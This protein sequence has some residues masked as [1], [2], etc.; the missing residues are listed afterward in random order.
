MRA[1]VVR[2]VKERLAGGWQTCPRPL[3]PD[4]RDG[5]VD[6]IAEFAVHAARQEAVDAGVGPESAVAVADVGF[7]VLWAIT[8]QRVV[9]LSQQGHPR[10]GRP[11][12]KCCRVT[13]DDGL[14]Y[15]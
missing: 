1:R 6:Q 9:D 8:W 5:F 2:V 7:P 14:P 12:L 3:D 4:R 10:R 11:P 13:L 15:G